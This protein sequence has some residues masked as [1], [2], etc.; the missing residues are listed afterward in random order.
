MLQHDLD[1]PTQL[2]TSQTWL[3]H[4]LISGKS[5]TNCTYHAHWQKPKFN[6]QSDTQ[7]QGSSIIP[8]KTLINVQLITNQPNIILINKYNLESTFNQ[9]HNF[10]LNLQSNI[11]FAQFSLHLGKPSHN[12]HTTVLHVQF[13][14]QYDSPSNPVSMLMARN[15]F[16]SESSF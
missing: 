10:H 11:M 9:P 7:S 15:C 5:P 2:S 4:S 12:S 3:N 6:L 14:A 16:S 1:I 8:N 13:P